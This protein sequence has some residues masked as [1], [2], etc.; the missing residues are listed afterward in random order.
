MELVMNIKII[1]ALM[2]QGKTQWV[3]RHFNENTDPEKRFIYIT[4]F[5]DEVKRA[6]RSCPALDFQD[7]TKIKHRAKYLSLRE[8]VQTDN[9]NIAATH[10][11]F[12]NMTTEIYDRI[13]E[14]N[15]TLVIDEALDCV[16]VFDGLTKHDLKQV[17]DDGMVKVE[18]DKTIR[19]NVERWPDYRGK[20]NEL[21]RL[22]DNGNL[23]Q[24]NG[25]ILIWQFP[26]QFLDAFKEVFI[27]TYMFA[28]QGMS[29]Y[30]QANKVQYTML[31]LSG[32]QAVAY[33]AVNNQ[34]LKEKLAGLI[35]LDTDARLNAIGRK[36]VDGKKHPMTAGWFSRNARPNLALLKEQNLR[37]LRLSTEAFFQ[38]IG[39]G[40][41]LN[42]VTTFKEAFKTL[43]RSRVFV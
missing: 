35:R 39:T 9:A 22:C 12:Q 10:A 29:N 2:G 13:K 31:T 38:K 43:S 30:L 33:D 41:K 6:K 21:K 7:P 3:F 36:P 23:V 4:P 42:M 20:F 1:D 40:A 28:G 17:F 37:K 14:R 32:G 8:L 25:S 5:L 24:S 16:E 34:P 19:W 18:A 27:C 15:Y 11:L 26:T